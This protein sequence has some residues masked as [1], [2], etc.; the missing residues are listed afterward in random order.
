M[1]SRPVLEIVDPGLLLSVQD[2]GRPG[3][4]GEG[5]TT[6]GAA[7][8]WSLAVA[9]ALV[10]NPPG[11]AGLEATLLGPTLRALVPVTIALAGAMSG[12]LVETGERVPVGA[13]IRLRAG[14]TLALGAADDGA[15]GYLAIPGGIDVPVVLGSRS[16]D[17]RAGFGGL[18]GR[19]LRP[20]DRLSAFSS[21]LETSDSVPE[22]SSHDPTPAVARWPGHPSPATSSAAPIRVMPGPHAERLGLAAMDAFEGAT[23]TVAPASDRQGLRLEGASV[24]PTTLHEVASHG[25]VTGAIQLPPDG[26]PIVLLVDRQPTGGYPVIA[27]VI[28]ADLARLGQLAPGMAVRFRVVDQDAATAALLEADREMTESV[29]HLR[30]STAWDELWRG[31]GG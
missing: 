14:S 15:R 30:E 31:A 26:R 3:L 2:A 29:A 28:T 27:V 4:A 21:D 20:G 11:A 17:L 25:V 5:V 23:W 13:S 6:G 8:P 24:S 12:R 7:D 22:L 19:A 18:D 10:A 1:P 9:N 16:T